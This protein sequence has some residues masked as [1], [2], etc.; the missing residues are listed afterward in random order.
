MLFVL[1]DYRDWN[2]SIF[3]TDAPGTGTFQFIQIRQLQDS[4]VGYSFQTVLPFL[5]IVLIIILIYIISISTQIS[6]LNLQCHSVFYNSSNKTH[7]G[8]LHPPLCS[9]INDQHLDPFY[10][11]QTLSVCLLRTLCSWN[12]L[13]C[14]F[15][16]VC[17]VIRFK[18]VYQIHIS[19]R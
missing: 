7:F 4:L 6:S 3:L 12:P 8:H 14:C 16:F 18:K 19:P 15:F 13:L 17:T 10:P 2:Y 5:L 11:I 9:F 1:S